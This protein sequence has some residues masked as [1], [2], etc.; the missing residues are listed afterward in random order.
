[1]CIVLLFNQLQKTTK[2]RTQK[3]RKAYI[4]DIFIK[5]SSSSTEI[6]SLTALHWSRVPNQ[7][8]GFT[9]F[10]R[11]IKIESHSSESGNS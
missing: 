7:P 8:N 11:G 3:I 1:M 6:I 4:N 9:I 5:S 10:N 2:N